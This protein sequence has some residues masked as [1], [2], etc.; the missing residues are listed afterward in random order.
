MGWPGMCRSGRSCN[1]A[2]VQC[3]G[4]GAGS[5]RTKAVLHL[6]QRF[7]VGMTLMFAML[8]CAARWSAPWLIR[9]AS[10]KKLKRQLLLVWPPRSGTCGV[11]WAFCQGKGEGPAGLCWQQQQSFKQ[12]AL[13]KPQRLEPEGTGWRGSPAAGVAPVQAAAAAAGPSRGAAGDAPSSSSGGE[14]RRAS[15]NSDAADVSSGLAAAAAAAAAAASPEDVG[16]A[17][18]T[19]TAAAAAAAAFGLAFV[20][21]RRKLLGDSVRLIDAVADPGRKR[22]R[23]MPRLLLLLQLHHLQSPRSGADQ[24]AAAGAALAGPMHWCSASRSRSRQVRQLPVMLMTS[25]S[26]PAVRGAAP[27]P[28]RCSW[29]QRVTRSSR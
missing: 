9:F 1:S 26:R 8:C 23:V 20:A 2:A 7:C 16:H 14:A 6:Y 10:G 18:Q 27:S 21:K 15:P 17:R 13:L 3:S 4:G 12:L 19:R 5:A 29:Q 24:R 28:R 11:S 22:R 25:R